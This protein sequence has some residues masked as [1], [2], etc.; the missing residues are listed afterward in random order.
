LNL[1]ASPKLEYW[2]QHSII[3]KGE[4]KL[5]AQKSFDNFPASGGIEISTFLQSFWQKLIFLKTPLILHQK[6]G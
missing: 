2:P 3:P 5:R 4:V 6:S 1:G